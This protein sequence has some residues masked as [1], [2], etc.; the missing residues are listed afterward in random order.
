MR[1]VLY[2]QQPNKE[3]F[4]SKAKKKKMAGKLKFTIFV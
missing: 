1:D 4:N 2:F 3:S